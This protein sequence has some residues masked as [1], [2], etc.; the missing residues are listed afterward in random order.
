MER[1]VPL[2]DDERLAF[3]GLVRALVRLDGAFTEVERAAIDEIGAEL[4]A[5]RASLDASPYRSRAPEAE[6]EAGELAA[7]A[8][9]M[10]ELVARAGTE[11]PD[12]EAIRRAALAVTRQDAREAIYE[13]LFTIG[14]ADA[15]DAGES[16]LLEW[17][18]TSWQVEVGEE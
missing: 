12:E 14:A 15:I 11:L 4:L 18:R 7:A 13:A 10:W 9:A 2:S 3:A 5:V 6:S 8:D 16:T 17:L 1:D